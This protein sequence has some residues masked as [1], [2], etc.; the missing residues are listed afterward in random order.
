VIVNK[1]DRH[2]TATEIVSEINKS[3]PR[4]V[5]VSTVKRRL[6]E[7]NLFGRIAIQKRLLRKQNKQING[8]GKITSTWYNWAMSKSPVDR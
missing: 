2:L 4:P 1:R 5:H 6:N 7:V 8:M 3:L